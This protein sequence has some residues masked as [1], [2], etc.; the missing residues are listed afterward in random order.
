MTLLSLFLSLFFPLCGTQG[1]AGIT[2]PGVVQFTN[3]HLQGHSEWLGA[4]PGVYQQPN[5]EIP[6]FNATPEQLFAAIQATAAAQPRTYVLDTEPAALQAA[7]VVRSPDGNFPDIIEIEIIPEPG[8]KSGLI[9]YSH[10]IYGESDYGKNRKHMQDW[11]Q[12][13]NTKAAS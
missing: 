7:Y 11:L 9:F 1:A 4:P 10:S 12:T 5:Q 13:L 3:L 6:V 8:N 2:P